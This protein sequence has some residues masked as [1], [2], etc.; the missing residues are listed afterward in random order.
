MGF[1]NFFKKSHSSLRKCAL[2]VDIGS[3]SVTVALAIFEDYIST[4]V[5]TETTKISVLSDLTYERFEK[6]MQK[7]LMSSMARIRKSTT[8]PIDFVN[9]CLS[10]P[11]YASQVRTAKLTRI[12]SFYVSKNILDDMIKRELKAFEE[13]EIKTKK[14][15][16]D[17]V[18]G[19]ESQTIR[20]KLNGYET[21]EP[22][23]MQ[24]KELELTMYLSVAS[25]HTLKSIEEIIE[26]TYNAPI[27]FSTFL[28]MTYLVARDFFPHQNN[29]MLID[30]GGEVSDISFVKQNGLEQSFSFPA[31]KN[32]ILRRLSNALGRSIDEAETLWRL[33]IE[34]KTNGEVGEKCER[35][36]RLAK[37]EWQQEFQKA[38]YKASRDL[39][40]PDVVLLSV[41]DDVAFWFSDAIKDE[42][43]HQ[44]TLLDKEFKIYFMNSSLFNDS[45]SFGPRVSRNS[46]VMIEAIAMR[47]LL[48]N[49]YQKK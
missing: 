8:A 5:A 39:S 25:Q 2:L 38:L 29:Y 37:V 21:H 41:D 10:S 33:H 47:Y 32:F 6:E 16:G 15:L 23:G 26:R 46:S 4:I 3:A 18:R 13:E 35:I 31:G 40:V 36:L 42:Q 19:I 11:W 17:T 14:I 1:L 44:N 43:F 28:S 27:M 24:A 22:L 48:E 7:A 12:T 20:A 30:I 45:L 49:N 9:V 34:A